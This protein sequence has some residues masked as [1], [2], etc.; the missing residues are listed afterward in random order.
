MLNCSITGLVIILSFFAHAMSYAQAEKHPL[1]VEVKSLLAEDWKTKPEEYKRDLVKRMEAAIEA[2][3][4]ALEDPELAD[5]YQGLMPFW[6]NDLQDEIWRINCED[7]PRTGENLLERCRQCKE[8]IS[9]YLKVKS[10][11]N[12]KLSDEINLEFLRRLHKCFGHFKDNPNCFE[13]AMTIFSSIVWDSTAARKRLVAEIVEHPGNLDSVLEPVNRQ[14]IAHPEKYQEIQQILS[15]Y[16]KGEISKDQLLIELREIIHLENREALEKV[17]AALAEETV[18]VKNYDLFVEPMIDVLTKLEDETLIRNLFLSIRDKWHKQLQGKPSNLAIEQLFTASQKQ[19]IARDSLFRIIDITGRLEEMDKTFIWICGPKRLGPQSI[20][21]TEHRFVEKI[22]PNT[23]TIW[24]EVLVGNNQGSRI[25]EIGNCGSMNFASIKER[26][27]EQNENVE[28]GQDLIISVEHLLRDN[29]LIVRFEFSDP[30][31]FLIGADT[32]NISTGD[33]FPEFEI[34]LRRGIQDVRDKFMESITG[35]Q[36]LEVLLNASLL[37]F[38]K[39]DHFKAYQLLGVQFRVF[40]KPDLSPKQIAESAGFSIADPFLQN[41]SAIDITHF[42]N[43]FI[44]ELQS[45]QSSL[46]IPFLISNK[47]GDQSIILSGRLHQTAKIT[48]PTLVINA[49]RGGKN[50]LSVESTI[51]YDAL[52]GKNDQEIE[53]VANMSAQAFGALLNVNSRYF[54]RDPISPTISAQ[55]LLF[56]GVAHFNIAEKIRPYQPKKYRTWGKIYAGLGII[57]VGGLVYFESKA[58]SNVDNSALRNRNFFLASLAGLAVVS[59]IHAL[60]NINSHNKRM[61]R[62]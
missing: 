9:R 41:K 33:S 18:T 46:S 31:G 25:K 29:N 35:Y 5:Q 4:L 12:A 55:S 32:C 43:I 10:R 7:C 34:N 50:L 48:K 56:P 57:S 15:K 53:Y 40:P 44:Q 11:N 17:F 59:T 38:Y 62:P 23:K 36:K 22:V 1:E 8:N 20:S 60:L 58:I 39:L 6:I 61:K 54:P 2:I 45:M 28:P 51:S 26:R 52:D 37:D 21:D 24:Q 27:I 47:P 30:D 3:K 13:E 49:S 42:R 19:P 16:F 14:T